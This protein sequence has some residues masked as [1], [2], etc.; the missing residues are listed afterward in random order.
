VFLPAGG[1]RRNIGKSDIVLAGDAAGL[2][3]PFSGEGIYYALRSG[4]IAAQT[5]LDA[6][7]TNDDWVKIYSRR[8]AVEFYHDFRLSLLVALLSGKKTQFQYEVLKQNPDMVSAI[9]IIMCQRHPYDRVIRENL[10]P[11]PGRIIRALLMN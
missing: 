7:K 9:S 11:M 4:H 10:W 5:L 3:D 1:F 8:C 2:V 6:L